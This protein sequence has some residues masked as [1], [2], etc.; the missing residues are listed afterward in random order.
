MT[1]STRLPSMLPKLV[2]VMVM[3]APVVGNVEG[4]APVITGGAYAS[5]A[6]TKADDCPR[7]E[8]M[9]R[10][11]APDATGNTHCRPVSGVVREQ[12]VVGKSPAGTRIVTWV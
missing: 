8:T 10:E 1:R 9:T 5:P 3:V 7:T 11:M 12:F 2:P 6:G 4:V